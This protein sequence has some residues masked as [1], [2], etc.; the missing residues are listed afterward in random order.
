MASR[1]SFCHRPRMSSPREAQPTD[2]AAAKKKQTTARIIAFL[3][4]SSIVHSYQEKAPVS[5]EFNLEATSRLI[6]PF[7]LLGCGKSDELADHGSH[8]DAEASVRLYRPRDGAAISFD[9]DLPF[10]FSDIHH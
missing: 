1:S 5:G 4:R 3:T 2:D 6:I 9:Y 10:L 8:R 7:A